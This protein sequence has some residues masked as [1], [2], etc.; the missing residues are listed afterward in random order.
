MFRSPSFSS[1]L[2]RLSLGLVSMLMA[3]TAYAF[4]EA[5]MLEA[6]VASGDLPAVEDRLPADPRVITP[7]NEIGTYGGTWRR[8]FKG[9]SD[10]RGPQKLMEP[11]I[12]RFVQ[13][14]ES[15]FDI[16]PAWASKFELNETA[17]E[18]TFYIREGLRWSDGELVTTEDVAFYFNDVVGEGNPW[19]WPREM[20]QGGVKAEVKII[21]EMT[22]SITFPEPAPIFIPT[23]G[24]A[25]IWMAKP[26]HYLSQFHPKY[27]TEEELA[28]ASKEFGVESWQD[29]WGRRGLAESFWLNPDVPTLS[30]WVITTPPPADQVV[31]TRN[32]YYYAVDTE[33]NQLPY[34]DK[35]THDLFE[36]TETLNLWVA[37]GR[38]DLQQRHIQVGNFPFF[39]ENREAGDYDVVI[40]SGVDVETL[41]PNQ[42]TADAVMAD[43][44]QTAD[45]REALNIAVDRE[46]INEIVYAGLAAP[47]Q[48][49]PAEGSAIYSE[50]LVTKWTEYDPDAAN[51]LLDG[52]G[53]TERDGDGFRLRPDGET[54]EIIISTSLMAADIKTLELIADFWGDLG[55][56]TTLDVMDRTAYLDRARANELMMGH[57]PMGRAAYFLIESGAYEATIADSPWGWAWGA[58]R[59]G[60]DS[61]VAQEPPADHMINK[62]WALIDESLT[63]KSEEE[64]REIGAEILDLHAEAPNWVGLVGG[65]PNLF[66]RSN[67]L[68]NFPEGFLRDD[69]TRDVGIIPTEQLYI[70]Q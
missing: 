28:A 17:T 43:L 15:T 70:K 21:D 48:A 10:D 4:N 6:L 24:R 42:T 44:F 38:I 63:A 12:V 29:L 54:L 25:Y 37:Q 45:F 23:L 8:A 16:Q 64:A 2:R 13:T 69:I 32:P 53:L 18:F 60:L 47:M 55:I 36:D 14:D 27:A 59:R 20:V 67:R 56:K 46:A 3:S 49:G 66:I 11:R 40:W 35:I 7:Y 19:P 39:M 57:W 1:S 30:P 68:G 26:A 65:A 61:A 58:A 31:F 5:P 41:W 62:V 33:G 34:I 51:A 9:A 50:A 22:F 52:L